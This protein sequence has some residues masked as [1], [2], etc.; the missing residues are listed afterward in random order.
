MAK[1]NKFEKILVEHPRI[2]AESFKKI[3]EELEER[4]K[5]KKEITI[6]QVTNKLRMKRSLVDS[7]FGLLFNF[8]YLGK[9]GQGKT[10]PFFRMTNF[11][12]KVSFVFGGIKNIQKEIDHNLTAIKKKVN[13]E[14]Y[15]D[16]ITLLKTKPHK[17][18]KEQNPIIGSIWAELNKDLE[19]C[20]IER[21]SKAVRY[22]VK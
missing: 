17:F 22:Y 21:G 3:L 7:R 2:D 4:T 16:L 11:E 10:I 15:A 6:T 14:K 12:K 9:L 20:K 13:K 19:L 1:E 8:E 18:F 5:N